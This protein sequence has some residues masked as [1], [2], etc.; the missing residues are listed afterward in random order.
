MGKTWSGSRNGTEPCTDRRH[1]W[2]ATLAIVCITFLESLAL[3]KGIN[4][5]LFSLTVFIIGGLG[6]YSVGP[7]IRGFLY[8]QDRK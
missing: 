3:L 6:G 4:G 7:L 1:L 8:G 2:V 5:K